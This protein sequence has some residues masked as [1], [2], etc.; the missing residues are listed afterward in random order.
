MNN[1]NNQPNTT[2]TEANE[3]VMTPVDTKPEEQTTGNPQPTEELDNTR[4]VATN[5]STP[6]AGLVAVPPSSEPKDA[7]GGDVS[8]AEMAGISERKDKGYGKSIQQMQEESDARRKQKK[9]EFIKKANEEY[10]PN[11]KFK[12][13]LLFMFFAILIAFV[14]FLPDIQQFISTYKGGGYDEA[15]K[16]VNGKLICELKTN[17]E[18]L[19][20]DYEYIF[21]MNDNKLKSLTQTL[22]TKGDRNLDAATLDDLNEKCKLLKEHTASLKGVSVECTY[23]NTTITKVQKINLAEIDVEAITSAYT[24][25]GGTYPEYKLDQDMDTLEKEMKQNGYQCSRQES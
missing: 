13:F 19:N 12:S 25:A 1:E 6:S 5:A 3:P 10:K 22:A 7:T 8:R 2:V 15:P 16:I 23:D 20:M 24:E 18:N 11:S 17:T 9:E 14:I 21:L 4:Q